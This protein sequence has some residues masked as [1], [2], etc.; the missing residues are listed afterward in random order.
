MTN[1]DVR[2]VMWGLLFIVLIAVGFYVL[3]LRIEACQ[4]L[5]PDKSIIE[6]YFLMG[7]R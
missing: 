4:H 5:F 7:A 6:C 3:S 2:A 1:R